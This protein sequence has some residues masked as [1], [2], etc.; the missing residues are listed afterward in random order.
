MKTSSR[1]EALD[2]LRFTAFMMVMLYHYFFASPSS[3]FLPKELTIQAFYFGDFGVDL[4]FLIS[5]FVISLSSDGRTATEFIKSRI[6]RIVPTYIIFGFIVFLFSISI[7]MV[8]VRE[9]LT[10]LFYSF[11]FFPQAFGYHFFSDIYWTIQ[12]EVTFYILV[13]LCMTLKLWQNHKKSLCF[14]W[15]TISFCNQFI[16]HNSLLNYIF[17]TEHAGH[18]IVGIVIYNLRKAKASPADIVLM[19]LST[20][21]IYCRMIG[22]NSY[23]YSSYGYSVSHISL[24]L[25]CLILIILTWCAS[26]TS[27]VGK[28]NNIVKFLGAMTYPLYLIHADIGFWSHAIFERKL[29]EQY[30]LTKE[31]IGYNT[32]IVIA[33]LVSFAISAAY[34]IFFDRPINRLCNKIWLLPAH[35]TKGNSIRE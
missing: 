35:F 1:I 21:L 31:L 18:F 23:I 2:G 32:T 24:L 30:P 28:F 20:V 14:T 6:N 12:K 25:A 26:N 7:P 34:I 11:T 19:T 3:G 9:R 4:F 29:W 15:L 16:L 8:E 13:F 22:F 33:I 17:L 5:G 10:S 27:E